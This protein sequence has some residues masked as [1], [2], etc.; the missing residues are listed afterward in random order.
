LSEALAH[1]G[2][3]TE[4]APLPDEFEHEAHE[5]SAARARS[6]GGKE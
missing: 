3:E 5:V 4:L 6:R 1:A 2:G